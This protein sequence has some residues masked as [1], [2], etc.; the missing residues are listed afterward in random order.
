MSRKAHFDELERALVRS[1]A[2]HMCEH[3]DAYAVHGGGDW[4]DEHAEAFGEI[5]SCLHDDPLSSRRLGSQHASDG[6]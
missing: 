6:C 1:D 4:P 5:I 3:L 2:D